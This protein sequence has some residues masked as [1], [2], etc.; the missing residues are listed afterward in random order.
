MKFTNKRLAAVA[1][2]AMIAGALNGV[3]PASA[4][5]DGSGDT[6]VDSQN[7]TGIEFWVQLS[8]ATRPQV[9]VIKGDHAFIGDE[10][11]GVYDGTTVTSPDGEFMYSTE[12]SD[13]EVPEVGPNG[14]VVANGTGVINVR[15]EQWDNGVIPYVFDASATQATRD[16]FLQAKN[17]YD[18]QTRVRF[19]PRTNEANYVRVITGNG[20]YS[21][22]GRTSL[23]ARPQGQEVSIGDGC[24]VNAARHELGHVVGLNH[25]QVRVDR[26]RF[27]QVNYDLLGGNTSQYDIK[28]RPNNAPIGT[29]DFESMMHYRNFQRNGRWVFESKTGFPN[30]FIGNDRIN[31]FSPGDLSSIAAI[32]GNP[33]GG[34]GNPGGGGDGQAIVTALNGKCID[35]PRS[36]FSEGVRL[37][38]WDCNG[39]NAQQ[40]RF[41]N[42]RVES[43]NGMCMDAAGAGTA[44]GTPIQIVRCSNHQAQQFVLTGAGDL[45]NRGANRCVDVAA[46]NRNN[47][48]ALIL[49]DCSG[50]PNQKWSLR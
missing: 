1:A 4:R 32:Y 26:D 24:S 19:V 14:E 16:K 12:Q 31:G 37:N 13:D 42:G 28:D 22:V 8:T 33:D 45:V 5:D 17:D 50:N 27:V 43:K 9:A 18:R 35:V 29:Y 47:G 11:V 10:V 40:W 7:P 44:N 15:R 21:Y 20:C 39:T 38:M 49:W 41:A 48:A 3:L 2:A 25:E 46:F 6:L 30:Q 36:N 34:G 23:S